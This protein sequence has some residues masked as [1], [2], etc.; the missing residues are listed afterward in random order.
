MLFLDTY[1]DLDISLW[2]YRCLLPLI[3]AFLLPFVFVALIYISFI[4]LFI[5]KNYRQVILR[6]VTTDRNFWEFGRKLVAAI[7]DAHARLYHGYEVVGMENLPKTG[8]ALIIFY[9]GAIPIDMYYFC[10]RVILQKDRLIYT[11]ADRFLF[12]VPGWSLIADA[13]HVSPGTVSSCANTL[14]DGNLLAI[15]PGGVYEA[16]FGDHYYELLWRNRTGFAK[17]AIE[18]KATIIPFF[19][20]NI[21][22]GFRQINF[23]RSFFL[24]IYNKVRFPILPI[25]GGFPVKYTS[26]LGKPIPFDP[27]L[28]PEQLQEKVAL[29]LEELINK[30]QRIPGSIS[31]GLLDRFPL[32]RRKTKTD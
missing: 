15:S 2:V 24:K 17:V 26:Y 4:V 30:H 16:Q 25:Y 27:S 12:K 6:S 13:F 5:Y 11:V 1:I 29:S 21:R 28:T 14:R 8:P 20:E 22:E 3:I 32:F 9:H 23:F 19:T 18:S 31:L 10:A 7:W